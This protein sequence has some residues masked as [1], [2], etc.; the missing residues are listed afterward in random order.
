MFLRTLG[1]ACQKTGWQVHAYCLMEN[2][3]HLVAET[4][5][6]N[7]VVG[8]K[9]LLGTYTGRFNRRHRLSG[10]LF[11]GRYK[12]LVID[13]RTPGYL[14]TACDYVH[15]NPVRAGLV[16]PDEPLRAF[17][18]SSYPHYLV[19][20]RRPPWL[21]VDRGLGEHGIQ[22]DAA[23]GRAEFQRRMERRRL[24]G[25]APETLASLRRGWRLGAPDFLSRLAERLGR[26]GQPHELA[27]QR[28]ETDTERAQ[29]IIQGRL[30][31]LRW[32]E[33]DLARLPKGHPEKASLAR[34]LRQETP[35]T[36]GW[37]ARRLHMGSPSYVSYLTS[38][39]DH[40]S[41]ARRALS[42]A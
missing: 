14:I 20:A 6:P 40:P 27:R 41:K 23:E 22:Q 42:P 7:L 13:E 29:C 1:E 16:A 33:S 18:W 8:M 34:Q 5:Q 4:P 38:R 2:H 39:G 28:R 21:R 15:L 19:P 31:S 11:S 12:S 10:H 32:L 26:R 3:F 37:I 36:R 30:A 35:M 9:W 24:E 17:R 25:E